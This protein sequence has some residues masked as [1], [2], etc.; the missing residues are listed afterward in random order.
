MVLFDDDARLLLGLL[1]GVDETVGLEII[2]GNIVGCKRAGRQAMANN[3]GR[4]LV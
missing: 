2:L 3:V 1:L 4:D